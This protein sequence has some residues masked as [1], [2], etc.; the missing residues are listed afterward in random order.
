MG[1]SWL[2]IFTTILIVI[3]ILCIPVQFYGLVEHKTQWNRTVTVQILW[4]RHQFYPAAKQKQRQKTNETDTMQFLSLNWKPIVYFLY[5]VVHMA[6]KQLTVELIQLDCTIGWNR[7]D[8]TAY[9]YG[10]F[11]A[12]LA[13]LP[14]QWKT[15]SKVSYI[16]DFQTNRQEIYFAGIIRCRVGQLIYMACSICYLAVQVLLEQK[17]EEQRNHEN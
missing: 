6:K 14:E 7:A 3:V 13:L 16:P 11:W 10:A 9:S 1:D 5:R 4:V 12:L 15:N 2:L 17:R 8:L